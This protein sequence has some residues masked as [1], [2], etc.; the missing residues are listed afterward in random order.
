MNAI[1]KELLWIWFMGV[2][3]GGGIVGISMGV[4]LI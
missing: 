2:V 3:T 4:W 1:T